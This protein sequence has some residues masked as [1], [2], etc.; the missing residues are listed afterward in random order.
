MP[1][2]D[3]YNMDNSVQ[4]VTQSVSPKSETQSHINSNDSI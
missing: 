4:V 2:Y 3:E 1:M